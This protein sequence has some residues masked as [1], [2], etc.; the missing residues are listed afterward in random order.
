VTVSILTFVFENCRQI[1][2]WHDTCFA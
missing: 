2:G 1:Q